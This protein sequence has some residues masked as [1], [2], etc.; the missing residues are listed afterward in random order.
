MEAADIIAES[1]RLQNSNKWRD[2][3]EYLKP[4]SDTTEDPELLW[5]L[6][7]SY[8]RIGKH[9]ARDKQEKAAV[10]DKGLEI[11]ERAL[12][13]DS[14]HFNI[15]KVNLASVFLVVLSQVVCGCSGQEFS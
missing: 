9:L 3:Y 12:A 14:N 6:I 7:R 13:K 8:Y 11:S 4:Y 10:A 15:Q 5:R 2:A 1:D